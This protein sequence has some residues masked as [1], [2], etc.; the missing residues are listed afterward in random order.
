VNRVEQE[1]SRSLGPEGGG[2]ASS[3]T[4]VS[5]SYEDWRRRFAAERLKVLYYLGLIANP[6]FIGAD[7]LLYRSHLQELLL[8]RA[9]LEAGLLIGFVALR[10][11]LSVLRPQLLLVF[12]VVFPNICVVHMTMVLGGFTSSY[13]NGLNLI[14]L[15]AAVIVPVSWTSH[16]AAQVATMAYYYSANFAFGSSS[17]AALNAAIENSFFLV[18]TCVALL[19]SVAMYER[20]QRAEFQARLSERHAREQ[21]ETSHRKLL[22]LDRLKT[23]FFANIS[24]ELRTPLTLSLGAY[25][26]LLKLSPSPECQKLIQSGLRNTGRLLFLINELLDL[27]KFE[28]GRAELKKRCIDLAAIVRGIAAN[29][30]SGARRRIHSRGMEQPVAVEADPL[31]IKKVLY[32][33]LSNAFKF[34]DPEEG[35]VWMRLRA[36][37][38]TI[39]LE[40]EDNGIGIPGDQLERIFD[41]FTQVE[42]SATRRYEGTGIGLALVKEIVDLHRGRI[43]VESKLGQGSTFTMTLPRGGASL[44]DIVTVEDEEVPMFHVV[45]ESGDKR[46]QAGVP[47][48]ASSSRLPL[49][50]VAEDNA[51][52]RAY[53]EGVLNGQYR[54]AL[55][56]DGVEGLEQAKALRP[57]L[58][59]TDAMMPRMSGYDLLKAVRGDEALRSIPVIFLT[60]R[61][62]TGARIESL[63]AGADDYLAKPFDENELLARVGNLIRSRAQER[64]LTELQKEKLTRFLP[65]PL[66]EMIMSGTADRFLKSHRTEV[67]VL[68]LDLRGFTA[69]AETADPEDVMNVLREY[70]A[71]MGRIIADYQGTLERFSGD[72]MMVFLNDPIPVQNHAEQGARMAVAMRNRLEALRIQWGKRGYELGAGVGIATGYATLGLVGFER[73]TDYAAIGTVTNL[74]ARL[75]GEAQHGQILV[76]ERVRHFVENLVSVEPVGELTLKGFSRPVAAYNI[77]GLRNHA[78]S[79][80]G[81][82]A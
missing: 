22:E 41:R 50:L 53:V 17:P 2:Q 61:A 27:A 56:K 28:S 68:F 72:A 81:G 60:A 45:R 70:Q 9:V 76:T 77:A 66:G 54:I 78:P 69:F 14:F 3:E 43:A 6:V 36:N 31:Q 1:L 18:W 64:E 21:L 47:S 37:E 59:L 13:Y 75:C 46:D 25:K 63:D 42:G 67:T 23:E 32:N 10:Q 30:D 79:T 65:Q 39:E 7:V 5:E 73:R 80:R 34:S 55:A 71:E 33:L 40:I 35:Q 44:A 29:F 4:A 15:A 57:D 52:M 11:Q 20:L 49:V 51:D 24:H 12:W 8:I 19:F 62:G 26:T 48:P 38:D 74:A 82:S 16:L 58:I